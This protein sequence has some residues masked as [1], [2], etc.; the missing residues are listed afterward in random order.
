MPDLLLPALCA[1]FNAISFCL[2]IA[3]YRAIR[4][5]QRE[6]H[7]RLMLAALFSSTLFLGFYLTNWAVGAE[8]KYPFHD[9]TR[10]LYFLVLVPHVIL[11]AV[12]TPF[13]IAIVVLAWR[14]A[15][16]W[17]QKLARWVWPVWV[18][19][20]ITGVLVFAMLR[21]QPLLRQAPPAAMAPSLHDVLESLPPAA[22]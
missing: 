10:P 4:H 3:G 22:E 2:L 21:L 18:Y 19:V 9:W 12:M 11:A 14:K 17:H 15:F 5:G 1:L 16:G 13:I 6:R 20:S 8:M 7:E